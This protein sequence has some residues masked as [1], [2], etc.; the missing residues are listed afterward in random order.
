MVAR[1]MTPRV[2]SCEP[3]GV[4]P[5]PMVIRPVN[6]SMSKEL[7]EFVGSDP[8]CRCLAVSLLVRQVA[9]EVP[10]DEDEEDEGEEQDD[11]EAEDDGNSNGYSE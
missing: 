10:D 7:S 2:H 1:R 8:A 5:S 9:R 6:W 4:L 11:E 3:P